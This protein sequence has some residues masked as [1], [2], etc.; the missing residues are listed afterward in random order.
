[1]ALHHRNKGSY[2]YNY[3]MLTEKCNYLF[4]GNEKYEQMMNFNLNI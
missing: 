4:N 1:M 3:K 2:K